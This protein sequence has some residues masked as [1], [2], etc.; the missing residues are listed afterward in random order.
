MPAKSPLSDHLGGFASGGNK[1]LV[2]VLA[3]S[4]LAAGCNLFSQS[5]PVG[6]IKSANGGADWQ[7]ANVLKGSTSANLSALSVSKLTFSP[8]NRQILFAGTYT[9]G[10]FKSEDSAASWSKILSKIFVYDVVVNPIDPKTIYAAGIYASHG[11]VL[12]TTDS[13]ASWNQIYNEETLD[14]AVRAISLNPQNPSQMVIGTATG[15]VIKSADAGT[16]WQLAK[17]FSDQVNGL[18][19]QNGSIYALLRGKGVFM[20]PGDTDNFTEMSA[21]I[22]DAFKLGNFYYDTSGVSA[23]NQFYIDQQSPGLM[24]VT[25]NKG[26]YKTTDAGKTWAA[27]ALPVGPSKSLPRAIAVAQSSSNI[28]YVSVGSTI[29]KSL[30]GGTNWQTQTITMGGFVNT[31]LVDPSLPQIVYA[32]IYAAQ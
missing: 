18:S 6:I 32:G 12:K 20:T 14:D 21:G 8:D 3:A 1:K 7:F 15:S 13:G 4:F 29:Y 24:Y 2:L 19:W 22:L 31:V 26:L 28:V 5:L 16:T 23:F 27:V 25:T 17:D 11:L 10:L 9:D 30:D